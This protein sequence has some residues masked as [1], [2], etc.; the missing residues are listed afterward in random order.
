MEKI[1]IVG[2]EFCHRSFAD[3]YK[4]QKSDSHDLYAF[5]NFE[6]RDFSSSQFTSHNRSCIG[7]ILNNFIRAINEHNTVP[8][9]VVFVLDDD[10]I[11]SVF[12]NSDYAQ[13]TEACIKWLMIEIEKSISIYKDFLPPRAKKTSYPQILWMAPP[14]H[15]YFGRRNNELRLDFADLLF[16]LAKLRR[17]TSVLKMIKIW[18]HKD[19][20]LYIPDAGRYTAD[21]LIRFW[22]SVD[23]VI[24]F[25]NVAIAL[26][27]GAKSSKKKQHGQQDRFHWQRYPHHERST[28][29]H[30]KRHSWT[31][32]HSGMRKIPTP[33]PRY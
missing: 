9:L 21:G 6:V 30:N 4:P 23:S 5:N 13:T 32:V 27:I 29:H 15:K 28:S 33:P 1:W 24:R 12:K 2:D 18:D 26:K 20:N 7:R 22:K 10:V 25:W 11:K 17:D 3:Y 19:S 8:K 31:T 16:H 14:T